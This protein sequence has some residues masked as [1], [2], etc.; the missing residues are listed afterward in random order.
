MEREYIYIYVYIY[1]HR[2]Y[3]GVMLGLCWASIGVIYGDIY[4]YIYIYVQSQYHKACIGIAVGIRAR[5]MLLVARG[6][7][8]V[9]SEPNKIL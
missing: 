7:K 2:G 1:T 5:S 6:V 3:I 4:I 9:R 8:L